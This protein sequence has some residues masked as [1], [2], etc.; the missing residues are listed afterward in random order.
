MNNTL[1]LDL[2]HTAWSTL[3]C[4]G[5]LPAPRCYHAACAVGEFM[6]V[7]GGET[8]TN[9]TCNSGNNYSSTEKG[10]GLLFEQSNTS[11][12]C[13]A[14]AVTF[15]DNGDE[16]PHEATQSSSML[17][18]PTAA[19]FG[20]QINK[21]VCPGDNLQSLRLGPTVRV[22]RC[23]STVDTIVTIVTMQCCF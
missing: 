14:A 5:P 18:V 11:S 23:C 8:V 12:G 10:G 4:D 17:N 22:S 15:I 21:G 16:V 3:V 9:F 1:V 20:K 13:A 6:V 7:H 19:A 2:N